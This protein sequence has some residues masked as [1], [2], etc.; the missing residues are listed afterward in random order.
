MVILMAWNEIEIALGRLLL[1]ID[2]ACS[3]LSCCC[4][5]WRC[6]FEHKVAFQCAKRYF[7]TIR[8]MVIRVSANLYNTQRMMCTHT[9]HVP[10]HSFQSIFVA[11]KCHV[12]WSRDDFNLLAITWKRL[13]YAASVMWCL[14]SIYDL[15]FFNLD[16]SFFV[17]VMVVVVAATVA[18]VRCS[19]CCL[20]CSVFVRILNIVHASQPAS[21]LACLFI[22]LAALCVNTIKY[23]VD[24]L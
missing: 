5:L 12:G 1:I 18:I 9:N 15:Q 22:H 13:H 21:L 11:R 19:R 4:C 23:D 10:C 14:F 7:R 20:F 16:I 3:Q 6:W 8:W 24:E 2:W 17:V